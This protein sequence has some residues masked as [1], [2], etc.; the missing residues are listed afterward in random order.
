MLGL[1]AAGTAVAGARLA[2]GERARRRTAPRRPAGLPAFIPAAGRRRVYSGTGSL[3]QRSAAD[4]RLTVDGKVDH[5]LSLGYE[6]LLARPQTD[7]KLDFQ[8]V[9]GWRV[10]DVPWT[11]VKLSALLDEAGVQAG[12]THLRIWSFD[13]V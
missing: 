12:A 6:D 2:R 8:C 9:T 10:A 11:G 1:A 3:P 7:L 5:P 13:G 4:Y